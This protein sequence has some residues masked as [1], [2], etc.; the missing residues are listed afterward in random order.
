MQYF[1]FLLILAKKIESKSMRLHKVMV[2][3]P[4]VQALEKKYVSNACIH[5]IAA[6]Y[7]FLT[8]CM[9]DNNHH[10]F[11]RRKK[12]CKGASFIFF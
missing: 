8:L 3:E 7:M 11:L 4:Q 2:W 6:V 10:K 12:F 9:N 1:I 5:S